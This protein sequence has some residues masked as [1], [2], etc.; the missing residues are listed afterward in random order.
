MFQRP[1]TLVLPDR[2]RP[3][4]AE[5][6]D[7]EVFVVFVDMLGRHSIDAA[8]PK[9]HLAPVHSIKDITIYPKAELRFCTDEV[10]GTF[11]EVREFIHRACLLAYD[12]TGFGE[13]FPETGFVFVALPAPFALRRAQAAFI[14]LLIDAIRRR[15]SLAVR[16]RFNTPLCL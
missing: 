7:G 9:S 1:Y 5:K 16:H 3:H 8:F 15:L 10:R 11:H 6:H 13:A 4:A 14:A 12:F 2:G